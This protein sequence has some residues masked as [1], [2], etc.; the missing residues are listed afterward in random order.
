MT[1]ED[2]RRVLTSHWLAIAVSAVIGAALGLGV[3]LLQPKV[4]SADSQSFVAISGLDPTNANI[5][6]GSTFIGQRI[7]SYGQ[8]VT[9]PDVLQPVIAELHLAETPATLAKHLKATSPAQT[10]LIV[11]TADYSTPELAA[12]ISNS[13]S[14]HLGAAIERIETPS[15]SQIAPVKVTLTDPAVPPLGPS[16]PKKLLDLLLGLLLGLGLALGY[17]LLRESLDTTVRSDADAVEASG[18]PNLGVITFDKDADSN[19]IAAFDLDSSRAEAMRVVRTN[20]QFVNV[21]NPPQRIL[22]TSSVQ[23]EGKTTTVVNLAV[24]MALAGKRVVVIDADLRKPRVAEYLGID[25]TIGLTNLLAGQNE[26]SD[27]LVRWRRGLVFVLPSGPIPPNPAEVVGSKSMSLV[28]DFFASRFDVVLIDAPPLLPVSDAAILAAAV[29]GA[30]LVVRDGKTH[31]SELARAAESL[32]QV[33][34]NL[35]GTVRNFVPAKSLTYRYGY[36]DSGKKGA[37]KPAVD[38]SMVD[39]RDRLA[40]YESGSGSTPFDTKLIL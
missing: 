13:V 38:S 19:P 35:L 16:S 10:V 24:T 25:G 32:R 23:G 12:D 40:A 8:L 11:V 37:S 31:G 29:D 9:S 4:Y 5:T 36:T 34:A 1:P 33:N 3:A 28:I 22:V 6:T 20:L 14:A 2:Y 18:A 7:Q 15:G 27:V 21:D 17:F 26:L 39:L 30:I